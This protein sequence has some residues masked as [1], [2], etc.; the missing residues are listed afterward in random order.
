MSRTEQAPLTDFAAGQSTV[1]VTRTIKLPLE[2]SQ[3]KNEVLRDGIAAY[4]QVAREMCDVLPSYPEHEWTPRHGH[5]YHH[6][7]RFLPDDRRYKTTLAQQ[8][9][10]DVAESFASWRERGQDGQPPRGEYGDAPYLGLRQDDCEIEAND[11]GYGFKARFVSYN[12]V[13]WHIDAGEYQREYLARLCDDDDPA[14]AGSAEVHLTGGRPVAHQTITWPVDVYEPG[15]VTT[16]VGVDLNDDPL[17]AAAVVEGDGTVAAVKMESGA[18]YRHH[19]ERVKRR[20]EQAM[21]EGD[22][23]AL[24]EAR[25]TYQKYTDHITNVASRRVVELARE[26][27]PVVI[28]PEDLTHYRRTAEDAIHDWPF[29]EIQEKIAYKATEEGIPVEAV[30]PRATSVTC[31]QCGAENPS[32]RDGREFN[33]LDCGYQVHADVNAAVNIA[34][35]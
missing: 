10:Q 1:D 31:R 20:R 9:Q 16:R 35:K 24:S 4:Q 22:L 21:A 29:A 23:N 2:S 11:R 30:D 28:H 19:R 32:A 25:L 26:H 15:D 18:E 7:K 3:T 17:V 34:S 14:R 5:M 33:C 27:A 6:A 13:W 8:A 12:P